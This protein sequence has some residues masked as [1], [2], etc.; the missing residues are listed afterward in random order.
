MLLKGMP[1]PGS[2]SHLLRLSEVPGWGEGT[3]Q[4]PLAHGQPQVQMGYRE[5][6]AM[7]EVKG[8]RGCPGELP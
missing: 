5:L 8:R 6:G 4:P 2:L 3:A 7:V 1:V